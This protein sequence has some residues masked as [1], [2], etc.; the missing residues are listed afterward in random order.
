VSSPAESEADT[1]PYLTATTG[2]NELYVA[3]SV[4]LVTVV[5]IL[6]VIL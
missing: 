4:L 2:K 1:A 5:I 3:L 6:L